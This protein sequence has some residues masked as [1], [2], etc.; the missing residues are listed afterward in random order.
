MKLL[1]KIFGHYYSVISVGG[2]L[3]CSRC[4]KRNPK[5]QMPERSRPCKILI[6]MKPW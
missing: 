6:S 1:C 5:L 4:M 2:L 3:Y